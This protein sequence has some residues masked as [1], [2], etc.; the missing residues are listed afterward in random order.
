MCANKFQKLPSRICITV[1]LVF[2]CSFCH[3][4]NGQAI[5]ILSKRMYECAKNKDK[6]SFKIV[7]KLFY[8]RTK[9]FR[10]YRSQLKIIIQKNDTIFY[11]ERYD[12]VSGGEIFATIWGNKMKPVSYSYDR[13]SIRINNDLIYFDS[14]IIPLFDP[15]YLIK[16]KHSKSEKVSEPITLMVTMITRL[17]GITNIECFWHL[18]INPF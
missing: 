1:Y 9:F 11:I 10:K 12:V 15:E 4:A 16:I 5:S 18:D 14:L 13:Q 6:S 2:F 17:K 3:P 8:T 7:D